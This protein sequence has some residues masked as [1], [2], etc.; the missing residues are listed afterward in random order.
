M[1]TPAPTPSRPLGAT[2]SP[3]LHLGL[4]LALRGATKRK[5]K[6]NSF[7]LS[8]LHLSV[9]PLQLCFTLSCCHF[10]NPSAASSPP[11]HPPILS[12]DVTKPPLFVQVSNTSLTSWYRKHFTLK[13]RL[14]D[15]MIVVF[16]YIYI[17]IGVCIKVL[18]TIGLFLTVMLSMHRRGGKE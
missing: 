13:T 17:Q 18:Q 9:S 12:R 7:F 15:D 11:R 10:L 2:R 3:P 16:K 8:G 5:C 6:A 4:K 14:V 1:E